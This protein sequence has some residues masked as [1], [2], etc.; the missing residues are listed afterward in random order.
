MNWLSQIWIRWL[1]VLTIVLLGAGCQIPGGGGGGEI[2]DQRV[3]SNTFQVGDFVKVEFSG[4]PVAIPPHEEHIQND[5]TITLP[6]IG[7]VRAAGKTAGELQRDIQAGY[8][9]IYYKHLNVTVIAQERFYYVNGEVKVPGRQQYL[10]P[11]TV[12]GAISSAQG[13]TD[14]ANRKTVRLTRSDGSIHT[15]NCVEALRNPALDLPVYPGDRIE[16][17]R[18]IL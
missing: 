2:P 14:F 4:V 9:P 16:V 12:T 5:G 7:A 1:P 15:I 8:V 17:Q 10:G 18:G 3:K 11:I 13:F 6:Y